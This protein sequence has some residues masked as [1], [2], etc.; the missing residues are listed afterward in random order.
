[1]NKNKGFTLVELLVVLVIVG[2]LAAVATPLYLQN[3]KR[4]RVSEAI[5]TMGLI[6]QA[7]R[8]YK[9][10]H[11]SFFDVADDTT[12][13]TNSSGKIQLGLPTSVSTGGT[14][15]PDPN[16]SGV[17]INVGVAQYFSN[18]SFYVEADTAANLKTASRSKLFVTPEPVDFIIFAKGNGSFPCTA[19]D[20]KCAVHPGDVAGYEVEMDNSGRIYVCYAN[21]APGSG[22]ASSGNWTQY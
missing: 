9:V 3:T 10:N 19:T 12:T 11:A 16:P 1:M 13:P 15:I 4:S 2:I 6:R 22:G 14:G 21:C 18:G 20:T 8:D 5:A 17:D 7:E